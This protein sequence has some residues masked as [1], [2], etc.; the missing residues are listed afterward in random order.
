MINHPNRSK[1]ESAEITQSQVIK[2]LGVIDAGL[3]KGVGNPIPGKMCVEAAVCFALGLPHGDDPKCVAPALRSLKIRLNDSHWSSNGARAKGLRRLAVIQLGS[4][5]FLD[6]KEFI[7]KCAGLVTK[8]SVPLAL[9]AVASI[10]K[11]SA[12]AQALRDAA[13]RCEIEGPRESA[14]NARDV[15]K[16]AGSY[17]DAAYAAAAAYAAYA[18]YARDKSLADFAEGIVQILIE[19][20]VPG[21]RWLPLTEI[22][23]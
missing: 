19:M 4:K 3:V 21:M 12:H 16:K 20:D 6:E 14:L 5:G 9:R 2:L 17:A 22:A 23:A 1:F 11:D 7:I 8:T 18:A 13:N 10:H 15:A